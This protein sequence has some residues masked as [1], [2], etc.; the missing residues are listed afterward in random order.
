MLSEEAK[1]FIYKEIKKLISVAKGEW[2][3]EEGCLDWNIIEDYMI[4]AY[5]MGMEEADV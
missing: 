1:E 2:E 3:A 5:K 4:K